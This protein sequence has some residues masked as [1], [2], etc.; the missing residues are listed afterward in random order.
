[1]R[2]GYRTAIRFMTESDIEQ[3]AIEIA[4]T[5]PL[6]YFTVRSL[7]NHQLAFHGEMFRKVKAASHERH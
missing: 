1:M 4:R 3:E 7:L 2:F 5:T 6:D